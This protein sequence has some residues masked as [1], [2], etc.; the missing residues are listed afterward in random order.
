VLEAQ[1]KS[2]RSDFVRSILLV[3]VAVWCVG[4]FFATPVLAS[5][6]VP[7]T[8][9]VLFDHPAAALT[10]DSGFGPYGLR[11]DFL[12][13]PPG[14]G[15]VFS[16]SCVDCDGLGVGN[17][18]F[19]TLVWNLDNS[20]EISGTIW[21]NNNGGFWTVFH[22]LTVIQ[23]TGGFKSIDG[24]LMLTTPGGTTLPP[25]AGK[26]TGSDPGDPT[27]LFLADGHRLDGD[28]YTPVARGW[29]NETGT[30]DWI[31]IG[32]RVPEP[33]TLLLLGPVLLGLGFFRK[34]LE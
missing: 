29:F 22:T 10:N 17:N 33:S 34:R 4:V 27:F 28:N 9:W 19:V 24:I 3:V 23:V 11:V 5:A 21:D 26:P 14:D 25:I 2:K 30:N 15:P 7:G 32:R 20:V 18:A 13:P 1:V 16:V 6:I 31:V 8:T 12:D